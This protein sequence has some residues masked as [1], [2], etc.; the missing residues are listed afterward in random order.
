MS[1]TNMDNSRF[2]NNVRVT[3]YAENESSLARAASFNMEKAIQRGGS[4][5]RNIGLE[6]LARSAVD[7]QRYSK[8]L[9]TQ[10]KKNLELNQHIKVQVMVDSIKCSDE[11]VSSIDNELA[12]L[13]SQI[14]LLKEEMAL[15]DAIESLTYLVKVAELVRMAFA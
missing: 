15:S 5:G 14:E 13:N 7:W 6:Q 4:P 12:C 2:T 1:H 11:L 9:L 10:F 8:K 3:A